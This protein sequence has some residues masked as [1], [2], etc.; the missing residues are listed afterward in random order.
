[1]TSLYLNNE[2]PF[3]HVHFNGIVRDEIGRKMSKSLGNSPDPLDIINTKGADA[4]RFGL[5][6]NTSQ[7]QDI[8]FSESLVDM[9]AN[10]VNKVWNASKFILS[11]LQDYDI[12]TSIMDLDFKLEDKYILSKLNLITKEYTKNMDDF[13]IDIACKYAYDF[14]QNDFCDWYLEIA[15]TRIYGATDIVDK[16]T[17]SYVLRHCLDY[18]LRLL[19]PFIPFVTEYIWQKVKLDGD[20]ILN[21]QMPVFDKLIDDPKSESDFEFLKESITAI[22]NIRSSVNASP[23]RKLDIIIKSEDNNELSILIDNPKILDKLAN[24]K[25]VEKQV[26]NLVGSRVVRNTQIFIPLDDLIDRESE[27]EKIDSQIKKTQQELDKVLSKLSNEQFISK[28]P[29]QIIEKENKIKNEL[30]TKISKLKENRRLY[31]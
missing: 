11:N 2:I 26:P 28:A 6:Y 21:T 7:C 31:E 1:M 13:N 25:I 29:A 4:L 17:A 27:L 10:F 5:L 22:R 14:F 15:K 30:E 12:N 16:N 18:S 23:S 9:G 19:H 3:K 20:T 24:C 8:R